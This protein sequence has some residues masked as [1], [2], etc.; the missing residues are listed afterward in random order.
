MLSKDYL[1]EKKIELEKQIEN[2]KATLN[3][4]LG[5]LELIHMLLKECDEN[6]P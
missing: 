2:L 6:N 1:E 4:H 3:A 5:A